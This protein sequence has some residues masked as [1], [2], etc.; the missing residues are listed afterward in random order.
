VNRG[1]VDFLKSAP[2]PIVPSVS[3][4]FLLQ[5][6]MRSNPAKEHLYCLKF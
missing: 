3:S 1:Q 6:V 2:F 5:D 4:I